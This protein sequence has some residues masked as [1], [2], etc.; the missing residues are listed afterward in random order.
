MAPTSSRATPPATPSSRLSL[1]RALAIVLPLVL[2][3]VV[4]WAVI[5]HRAFFRAAGP[6]RITL[7]PDQARQFEE[8]SRAFLR[9][10]R[11]AEALQP[12]ET[13]SQAYPDN[14]IYLGRLANIYNHLGRYRDEAAMWE[15]YMNDAP[16]PLEACPRI[17]QAYWSQ[18]AQFYPQAIAS[19]ERCLKLDP[20]NADSYFFLAHALEMTGN[21]DRASQLYR[22]GLE[23]APAYNDLRV[24]LSRSLLRLDKIPEARQEAQKV[25][26]K[27]ANNRGALL[28]MGMIELHDDNYAQAKVYL[29]H[30][31]KLA[32]DDPDFHLLLARI[33]ENEKD[34]AEALRQY[35]RIVELRPDDQRSRARR[36]A[37]LATAKTPKK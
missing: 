13:L 32:D 30:G 36:D 25:L 29:Q 26:D 2:L 27:D 17:G 5:A 14:H 23:I 16:T 18:G 15:R 8:Q 19:F 9:Q 20:K 22:Q 28:A 34:D 7:T 35:T 12:T 24:G 3:G 37:L 11:Y 31:V 33:A 6:Q 10:D 1:K 21:F 4:Y